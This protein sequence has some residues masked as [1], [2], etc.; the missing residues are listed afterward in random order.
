[1]G[2]GLVIP[3]IAALLLFAVGFVIITVSAISRS[4]TFSLK[5]R[6]LLWGK[7][8]GMGMFIVCMLLWLVGAAIQMC[9]GGNTD[10]GRINGGRYYLENH[11]KYAEVSKDAWN[12]VATTEYYFGFRCWAVGALGMAAFFVLG[13]IEK[14]RFPSSLAEAFD[15]PDPQP[16]EM[17]QESANVTFQDNVYEAN[18]ENACETGQSNTCEAKSDKSCAKIWRWTPLTALGYLGIALLIILLPIH[19]FFAMC[20][21]VL[22]GFIVVV[23]CMFCIFLFRSRIADML[24]TLA[25]GTGFALPGALLAWWLLDILLDPMQ[26]NKLEGAIAMGF[27]AIAMM[28]IGCSTVTAALIYS[29]GRNHSIESK[30]EQP[31]RQ[32]HE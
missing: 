21:T 32:D 22:I 27:G 28:A 1:M 9:Y 8:L 12:L 6:I 19:P 15:F 26:D 7:M 13:R 25:V 17:L 29:F 5:R 4:K 24:L 2:I 10:G 16:C 20:G 11:G 30:A 3:F 23:I 31:R 18:Q 14:G